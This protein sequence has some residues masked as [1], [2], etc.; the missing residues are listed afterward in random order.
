MQFQKYKDI[1]DKSIGDDDDMIRVHKFAD[2][3]DIEYREGD[4]IIF[5]KQVWEIVHI[6]LKKDTVYFICEAY[7]IVRRDEFCN[8]F[9]LDKQFGNPLILAFEELESKLVYE[10]YIQMANFML[11][12]LH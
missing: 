4:L 9:V 6:L 12:L 2:Y 1:V 3:A 5:N 8:S 7:K 10:K 11:F